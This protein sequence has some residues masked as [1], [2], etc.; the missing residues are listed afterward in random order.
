VAQKIDLL[1]IVRQ[2]KGRGYFDPADYSALTLNFEQLKE[3]KSLLDKK[4]IPWGSVN[5]TIDFNQG[6]AMIVINSLRKGTPP[7]VDVTAFSVGRKNLIDRF[8]RELQAITQASS[9]IRFM[10][11]DYGCGKTHALYLLREI[12]F[13]QEFVVSIVTLNQDSCPIHDFMSVYHRIMWNLRTKEERNKPAI[14]NALG[15]WLDAIRQ[16]GED[17]ARQIIR[18]LPDNFKNALHAYHESTSPLK[19]DEEKRLLVL[20]YLSGEDVYLRELR[21]IGVQ[22]HI[23]SSNALSMLGYMASLFRNL[24]YHGICIL[25]DEAESIHS[26]ARGKHQDQAYSNL[27]QIV[28]QSQ[29]TSHCLFLYATTP[30]FFDNYS[31]YWPSQH[32]IKDNDIFELERLEAPELRRL[33][34]NLCKIYSTAYDIEVPEDVEQAMR[35]LGEAS[36]SERIGD[37]T[38]RCIAILDEERK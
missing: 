19:P 33:A 30:S 14:E 26:F 3:L 35:E 18:M 38:R 29:S 28:R 4:K 9:Q 23:D 21:R 13:K 15:R 27:F 32:R 5:S 24:R 34:S 6:K 7:P 22:H 25:F 31:D 2:A 20:K 1:E 11:A 12:A 10:N 37:F 36:V 17:R 16:S 8:D